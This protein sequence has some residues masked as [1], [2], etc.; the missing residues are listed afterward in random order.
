MFLSTDI[1]RDNAIIITVYSY[2]VLYNA[3][4]LKD[5][6][7]VSLCLK[8]FVPLNKYQQ[9][10]K[11]EQDNNIKYMSLWSKKTS[12]NVEGLRT[13]HKSIFNAYIYTKYI[14]CSAHR[15]MILPTNRSYNH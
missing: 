7:Y 10:M 14:S 15:S 5:L 3:T 13:S 6:H 2:E 11:N 1:P 9:T 4:L 8:C 12:M